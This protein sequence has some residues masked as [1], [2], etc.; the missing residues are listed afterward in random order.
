M[1]QVRAVKLPDKKK[2]T[3]NFIP[4]VDGRNLASVKQKGSLSHCL[5]G[6]SLKPRLVGF[7]SRFRQ[8]TIQQVRSVLLV[9][10]SLET[11]ANPWAHQRH[12]TFTL[13]RRCRS[14]NWAG[15]LVAVAKG[16]RKLFPETTNQLSS[17]KRR[18]GFFPV[19]EKKRLVFVNQQNF[20]YTPFL[21]N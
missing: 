2:L 3:K 18:L 13:R 19:C 20:R 15:R 21:W 9:S 8:T 10:F 5:P 4:T 16:I 17:R 6:I 12:C 11:G 14:C 7:F 1:F